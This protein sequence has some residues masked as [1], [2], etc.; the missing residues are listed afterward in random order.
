M[1]REAGQLAVRRLLVP[2]L[3]VTVVVIITVP[4]KP[5]EVAG[6]PDAVRRAPPEPPGVIV[7][8]VTLVAK[9]TPV[10]WIVRVPELTNESE[11]GVSLAW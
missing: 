3:F 5:S 4:V 7:T 9:L 2:L 6:R 10:T 11:L 1:F 8:L